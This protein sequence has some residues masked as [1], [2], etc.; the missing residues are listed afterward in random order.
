MALEDGFTAMCLAT[1]GRADRGLATSVRAT[2]RAWDLDLDAGVL[3]LDAGRWAAGSSSL[4]YARAWWMAPT[5][6][7][8][9]ARARSQVLRT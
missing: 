9:D 1:G 5:L 2:C 3:D 8:S 4:G 6:E 7:C